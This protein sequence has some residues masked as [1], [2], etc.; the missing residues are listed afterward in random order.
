MGA[1]ARHPDLNS[2]EVQVVGKGLSETRHL[3]RDRLG[4]SPGNPFQN[5]IAASAR[6][7]RDDVAA[8]FNLRAVSSL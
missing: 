4:H 5:S 2:K 3:N 7:S 8:D 1:H 6:T